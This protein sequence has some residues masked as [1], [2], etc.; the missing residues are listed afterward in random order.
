MKD[1]KDIILEA[2][3]EPELHG[4]LQFIKQKYGKDVKGKKARH[5]G[6]VAEIR[7]S[8]KL[9]KQERLAK[10]GGTAKKLQ[11]TIRKIK[12]WNTNRKET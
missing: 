4:D 8:A 7:R 1:I 10:Q 3:R 9:M 12:A 11:Q 6:D 5:A 2:W